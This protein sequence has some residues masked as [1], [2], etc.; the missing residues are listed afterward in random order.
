MKKIIFWIACFLVVVIVFQVCYGLKIILPSNVSWLMSVMHDWGAHYLGW[1]FYRQEPWHFPIGNVDGYFYPI[2]TNVGY[3]DSIPLLAI[4]FKLFKGILPA[5]FQYFGLWLFVCHL[6]AAYYT[7]LLCRLFKVSYFMTF[8]AVIFIVANPVLIYRGLHPALCAHW[9]LVGSIYLYFLHPD[10]VRPSKILLHQ[11]IL[12]LISALVNPYLCFMVLG[13]SIIIAVKLWFVQKTI[14]RKQLFIYL[15]GS[16]VSLLLCWWLVGMISFDNKEDMRVQGGYGLYGLNL[17]SLHNPFGFSSVLPSMKHVS[18][19]QYEGFMYLGLGIFLLLAILTGYLVYRNFQKKNDGNESARHRFIFNN[20]NPW[21]L[22]ILVVVYTLFSITHVVTINEHVLFKAPMPSFIVRLGEIFRAS[23]R[24]FWPVYYLIMF[25]ILIGI[26]KSRMSEVV[27]RLI[28]AIAIIVQLYDTKLVLT[29][30]HLSHGAYT[31]PIDNL[32]WNQLISNFDEIV[33]YPPFETTNLTYLDYQYFSYLAGKAGKKINTGYIARLDNAAIQRV[34]DTL[35]NCLAEGKLSPRTL[36]IT[37]PANLDHF[38]FPLQ[39]DSCKLNYLDGYYYLYSKH[40]NENSL[41]AL[42]QQLNAI[43]EAKIDAGLTVLGKKATFIPIDDTLRIRQGTVRHFIEN[44]TEKEGWISVA[45]WAFNDTANNN[46]SDSVFIVLKNDNTFYAGRTT[47]Q[48]RPDVTAHFK[49]SYLDNAGFYALIY[50]DKLKRGIYE[51]KVAVKDMN[52]NIT[53]MATDRIVK[54]GMNEYAPVEN[55]R[56]INTT[57]DIIFNAETVQA[58]QQSVSIGGWA[59]IKDQHMEEAGIGIVLRNDRGAYLAWAEPVP[60]PDVTAHFKNGYKLDNSGFKIKMQRQS[61]PKGK[62]QVL[63]TISNGA[64]Q[65]SIY[66]G[67]DIEIQ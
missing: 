52:G 8:I 5:D 12:L 40:R 21:P 20:T 15:G 51:L 66:T 30:R 29:Y 26:A 64:R 31:P 42:S 17:N 38:A 1:L 61:F 16:L 47:M 35:I 50:K 14:H 57:N 2:G 53:Y 18:A 27:K 62:Y 22:L 3:T 65:S 33:F 39:T 60:R 58:D 24:F 19:H 28:L 9:L 13:F 54:Y 25:F 10:Q 63:I 44:F 6:L 23:A 41:L 37:T 7:V 49:K 46:R 55:I 67:K 34:K 48:L 59:F 43:N 36:Y 32:H 11:L 4:F 45:G 56:V